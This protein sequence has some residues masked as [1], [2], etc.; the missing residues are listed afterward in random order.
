MTR[1]AIVACSLTLALVFFCP[2]ARAQPDVRLRWETLDTPHFHIHF[3]QGEE[4][5][6]RRVATVAEG[7]VTR[8][9]GPLGW[10]QSQITEIV[11]SDPT[12]DA[13]GSATAVPYNTIRLYVTAP[14]DLSPLNEYD[15][16]LTTLVTHEYTHILH[17][18]HIG[19]IPAIVNAIIGKQ[20]APNQIQPRWIL[21]GL[22]V[23]EET[24]HT[25]GGRLRSSIWDMYLRADALEN[26]IVSLDQ[27]SSG[28]NRWPHG[29]IWY[30]Y[31]SF[32]MQYVADRWGN[33][34]LARLSAVYGSMAI[35]WQINRAIHRV[36][37]S[38]W[39]EIYGDFTAALRA[40]YAAQQRAIAAAGIEEGTRI[41]WHGEDVHAPRYLPD[42][43]LVY[44][45]ADGEVQTQVRA[46][47][48]GATVPRELDWVAS[49]ESMAPIGDRALVVS[50]LGVHRDLYYYHDLYRWTLGRDA[51][52][53][54][55]VVHTERLTDGMRAMHP[56]V[57]PDHEHVVFTVNHRGT[58]EL[59]EMSLTERTPRLLFRP[60]RF[61]Q[62]Y[63]PR[64]S[65]DGRTV[66]FSYWREGGLRDVMLCDR[67][68]GTVREVTHDR[69]IDASPVWTPDGRW[70]L[71]TSDRTGVMN[72]YAWE[73]AT[74][75]F[76]Q[77]TNVVM[78]AFE[79]A[80]SPDGQ[81]LVYVGY[82][83][84]GYDLYRMPLDPSRWRSVAAQREDPEPPEPPTEPFS[85]RVHPYNPW[86]TL[87]P[88]TWQAG[89]T[90][91]G[92]GN[93]LTLSS[94]GT[95]VV[96][97]H[98][99]NALVGISLTRGYPSF[100]AT[101]QYA[102]LRPTLRLHLYRTVDAAGGYSVGTYAPT[103]AEQ[104]IGG[105]AEADLA[106][107]GVWDAHALSFAY[108]AQNISAL[109]GLP[110][111]RY[112]DP[113]GPLPV[114]PFRG[115][116]N[117][118]RLG[119]SYTKVQRY[120]YSI[121]SQEGISAYT[122]VHAT[123]TVLG[124]DINGVDVTAA[125]A[126]YLPMP[127]GMARQRHILA[128]HVG[129]GFGIT[130]HGQQGIFA[131]GG[132]PPYTAQNLLDALRQGLQ[133]G[134]IA[135]RGYPVAARYGSQF[136]LVNVE[137]RFPIVWTRWGPST[138]PVFFQRIYASVFTDVGN[139]N[140]GTFVP[141]NVAVGSGAEVF[142]DMVAGYV[143]PITLRVGYA[144]GFSLGGLDQTYWQLSAPF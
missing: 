114:L 1:A 31:G 100:D 66:A 102:G 138:L 62:V 116:Y 4:P 96:G 112:A 122:S 37:G 35:P 48:P 78:G 49:P 52:G 56:D 142:V 13:N 104:R 68:T 126:A 124:S 118:V 6:A 5:I 101:Y 28:V 90:G 64:Y 80:V 143:L 73:V 117:G 45:A 47:D 29:N 125:F 71:F 61:E 88:R 110:F 12:D 32:L 87:L 3:Y 108:E 82:T 41:T 2:L 51:Q 42:G 120:T 123:D 50:D 132:F 129:A 21:E 98:S 70:L 75:A 141:S 69:A 55:R 91:N 8:L 53:R 39:E 111:G 18:D 136:E 140:F 46:L 133:S 95:D 54:T 89:M 38:T 24:L 17:T 119:W 19:G 79:P 23:Y 121:T 10:T 134:T 81:T 59:F 44:W 105:E 22:A 97:L 72:V 109:G 106:F 83:H 26:T 85:T 144:H 86:P 113:N 15:D 107:P 63:A 25:S 33:Q 130:D 20:W 30:L 43:T 40:R 16:W 7:V 103:W 84:Q 99:W 34:A 77:V 128:L 137:Y 14:E 127:W 36:T 94:T 58:T 65:P 60:R 93:V 57:S 92:F 67:A 74:G 115:W 131:L 139:A 135:L 9:S 76:S 11:L 27:L